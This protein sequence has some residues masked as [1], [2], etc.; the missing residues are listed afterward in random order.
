M[1]S[2]ELQQEIDKVRQLMNETDDMDEIIE[3]DEKLNELYIQ[4]ETEKMK[5]LYNELQERGKA[6]E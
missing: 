4:L 1:S 6:A 5:E 3:H 2:K